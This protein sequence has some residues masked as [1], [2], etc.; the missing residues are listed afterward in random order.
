M[1]TRVLFCR[2][3]PISPDPRVEKH[4]QA[5]SEVGYHVFAV[6]WDRTG[7]LLASEKI[8]DIHCF[9]LPIQA[10]Y[11]HGMRNIFGLLRWQWG[12]LIWLFRQRSQ[13]DAIHA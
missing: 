12:L 10:K 6:A 9:R 13:Y 3:N 8:G 11:A 4:A 2:S 5:L 1:P 7:Q